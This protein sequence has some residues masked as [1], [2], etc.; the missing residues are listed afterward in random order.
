[1]HSVAMKAQAMTVGPIEEHSQ[2][3]ALS[4]KETTILLEVY[5]C[6]MIQADI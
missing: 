6:S 2:D 1:M 4:R 3:I 5:L